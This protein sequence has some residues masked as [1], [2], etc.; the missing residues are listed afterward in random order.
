MRG[1]LAALVFTAISG[2]AQ[3]LTVPDGAPP[4]AVGKVAAAWSQ[5]VAQP[6]GATGQPV[7]ELR[8]AVQTAAGDAGNGQQYCDFYA[9][10]TTLADGATPAPLPLKARPQLGISGYDIALC[11]A[12]LATDVALAEAMEKDAGG[13]LQA[14]L[15]APSGYNGATPVRVHGP[16]SL[17]LR[18]KDGGADALRMVT[19]GDT[20]CRGRM[21]VDSH[22]RFY[23][24]C[25]SW[26]LPDLARNAASED[27]DLVVHVGDFRYFWEPHRDNPVSPDTWPYWMTDFFSAAQPL[28]LAAPWVFSRGNHEVCDPGWYG[29]GWH[30]LFGSDARD[31]KTLPAQ[32]CPFSPVPMWT[33]DV[34]PGGNTAGPA[35]HRFVIIDSAR[36]SQTSLTTDFQTALGLTNPD[37]V[38]WVSHVPAFNLLEYADCRGCTPGYHLG[39]TNVQFALRTA[40]RNITLCDPTRRNA[41]ACLPSTLLLGHQHLFQQIEFFGENATSGA[42]VFP[43]SYIVGH[44][45][46]RIDSS[47]LSGSP[48]TFAGFDLGQVT[49]SAGQETARAYNG[50]VHSASDFGYVVWT[51]S[52]ATLAE[53]SGWR[54]ETRDAAGNPMPTG[55]PNSNVPPC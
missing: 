48:C 31:A 29:T 11:T 9:V 55:Q 25:D 3:A 46:T 10:Q 49:D 47:G 23:Q 24:D 1:I 41:P 27:P 7:T 38:W 30:Y 19:L 12:V 39:D 16:A 45:G 15:V 6:A 53:P 5:F 2:S 37:S 20:G 36:S 18:H 54:A 22:S 35:V 14:A 52:A 51:R 40:T 42:Y 26:A 32:A 44:G 34:A 43:Q 17:G 50:V 8:L 4:V 28:L 33:L 21:A 13:S